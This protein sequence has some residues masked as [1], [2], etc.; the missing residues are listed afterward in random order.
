MTVWPG[1]EANWKL[2]CNQNLFSVLRFYSA[3]KEE[4]QLLSLVEEKDAG[5]VD[6]L[7]ARVRPKFE[8]E[9]QLGM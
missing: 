2:D 9:C 6:L 5:A 8:T 1:H 3:I 4:Q 7:L